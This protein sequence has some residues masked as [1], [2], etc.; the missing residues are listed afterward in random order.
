MVQVK[1]CCKYFYVET[2]SKGWDA[3]QLLLSII[4]ERGEWIVWITP[5]NGTR[6]DNSIT[7]PDG[8]PYAAQRCT[9]WALCLG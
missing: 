1:R 4:V 2:H 3:E 5:I 8:G 9:Y 6:K 7:I